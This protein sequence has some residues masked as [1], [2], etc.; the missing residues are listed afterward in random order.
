MTNP[1]NLEFLQSLRGQQESQ[2]L[3]F[4]SSRELSNEIADK[5]AKFISSQI[6]PAVSAFL[7]TDGRHLVI[8]VEEEKN[9][10]ATHLS[11]GV[12]ANRTL[13]PR[14]DRKFW[15]KQKARARKLPRGS[16]WG[17]NNQSYRQRL[18]K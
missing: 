3:E 13:S 17:L 12:P 5:R 1:Y 8:G 7:N 9:A 10:I 14:G 15:K 11:E 16:G 18:V 6:V 2:R 4:K